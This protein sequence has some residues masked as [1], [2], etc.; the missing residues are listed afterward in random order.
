MISPDQFGPPYWETLFWAA[1]NGTTPRKRQVF[2]ALA[3]IMASSPGGLPCEDCNKHFDRMS[4]TPGFMIDEYMDSNERLVYLCWKWKSEVNK[5]L[6][7]PNLPWDKVKEKYLSDQNVCTARCSEGS[8][9][10]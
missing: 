7:K 8:D 9:Q 4:R 2:K 5:R 1:A 6:K 3:T 10:E